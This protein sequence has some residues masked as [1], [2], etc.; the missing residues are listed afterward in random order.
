VCINTHKSSDVE[1]FELIIGCLF[2]EDSSTRF[3]H[4][5][6]TKSTCCQHNINTTS[7]QH[8]HNINS[9]STATQQHA[10]YSNTTYTTYTTH[11]DYHTI[12]YQT[13]RYYGTTLFSLFSLCPAPSCKKREREL[14]EEMKKIGTVVLRGCSERLHEKKK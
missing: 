7:T 10:T 2:S 6:N 13:V 4:D 11:T 5:F 3:Q 12:L 14:I 1:L 9:N 8:Q